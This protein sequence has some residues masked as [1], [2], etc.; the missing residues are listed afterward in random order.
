MPARRVKTLFRNPKERN[1]REHRSRKGRTPSH[2]Y[3]RTVKFIVRH[4]LDRIAKQE[5]KALRL[6]DYDK[7]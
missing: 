1:H 7:S 2:I 4:K 5:A 6:H 3:H